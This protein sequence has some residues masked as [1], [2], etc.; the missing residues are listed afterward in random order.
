MVPGAHIALWTLAITPT[1]HKRYL[2]HSFGKTGLR[3]SGTVF[4]IQ[5]FFYDEFTGILMFRTMINFMD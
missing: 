3:Q 2:V 1:P 4:I 5:M